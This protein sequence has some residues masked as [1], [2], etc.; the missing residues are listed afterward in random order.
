MQFL[1]LFLSFGFQN[2]NLIVFQSSVSRLWSRADLSL[3]WI[4]LFFDVLLFPRA[5]LA[6]F[7]P[8]CDFPLNFLPL[9]VGSES[10]NHLQNTLDGINEHQPHI[11][12]DDDEQQ[13]QQ[14]NPNHFFFDET[15]QNIKVVVH[16]QNCDDIGGQNEDHFRNDQ[17]HIVSLLL[18]RLRLYAEDAPDCRHDIRQNDLEEGKVKKHDDEPNKKEVL[19]NADRREVPLSEVLQFEL[20]VA[21]A[22]L[23]LEA[24]ARE[25]VSWLVGDR[26]EEKGDNDHHDDSKTCEGR[27]DQEPSVQSRKEPQLHGGSVDEVD[28]GSFEKPKE[29]SPLERAFD[30]LRPFINS[31]F[32]IEF[33]NQK[34]GDEKKN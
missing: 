17:L 28:V 5:P 9:E 26:Q 21:K 14:R 22:P 27:V 18:V 15:A 31:A 10:L 12:D 16:Q 24:L 2:H 25:G 13:H 8:L 19:E 34:L 33:F 32:P 11:V 7:L 30:L 20:M 4:L 1:N 29:E 3:N 23:L 6:L